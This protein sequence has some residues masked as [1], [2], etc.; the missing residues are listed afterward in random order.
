LDCQA[1][2]LKQKFLIT[3]FRMTL[4]DLE[5]NIRVMLLTISMVLL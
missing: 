2:K 4:E 3:I 1:P 5:Y